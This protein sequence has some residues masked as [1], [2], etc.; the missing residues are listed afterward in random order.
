MGLVR[1]LGEKYLWV[2]SLCIIQDQDMGHE[3]AN[4]G[5]IYDRAT[6]TIVEATAW[7]A[8]DGL[9]GLRGISTSRH[10]SAFGDD[11]NKYLDPDCTIW[12]NL[13]F[14]LLQNHPLTRLRTPAPRHSRKAN[15]PARCSCFATKPSS[16]GAYAHAR[17]KSARI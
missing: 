6:L 9:W 7:D 15:S 2:D 16:G 12:V 8:D 10:L 4:I 3:L 1:E 14:S 13:D 17:T 11:M 5:A